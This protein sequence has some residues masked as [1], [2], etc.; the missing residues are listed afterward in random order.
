MLVM[1]AHKD[2]N[3]SV[4]VFENSNLEK[5]LFVLEILHK[6]KIF[7]IIAARTAELINDHW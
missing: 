6:F 2:V 7:T 4:A 3:L 5:E 1:P